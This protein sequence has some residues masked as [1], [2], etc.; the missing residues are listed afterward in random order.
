MRKG[1]RGGT[2]N[3]SRGRGGG[4]IRGGSKK[5][6]K[7]RKGRKERMILIWHETVVV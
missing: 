6:R 7:G 3:R 5:V 1:R 4:D 2:G